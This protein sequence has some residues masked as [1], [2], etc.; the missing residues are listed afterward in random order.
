MIKKTNWNNWF[1]VKMK[2]AIFNFEEYEKFA[3][4]KIFKSIKYILKLILILAFIFTVS[5]IY[6]TYENANE[7]IL[8]VSKEIPEFKIEKDSLII[9][10]E[11]KQKPITIN[12]ENNQIGIIIDS[13]KTESKDIEIDIS[14]YESSV[15]FLKNK[16]VISYANNNLTATYKELLKE[17]EL[18]SISKQTVIDYI[19]NID[20]S[21]AYTILF[22]II[23]IAQF[24][25]YTIITI[26][27]IILL[28]I[29]GFLIT[30][31]FKV[32]FQYK[33]ILKISIYALTLPIILSAIYLSIN[34]ITGFTIKYFQTAYNIISYIYLITAILTIKTDLIKIKA[35][36][37]TIEKEAE[38][39]KKQKEAEEKLKENK[40]PKQRKK[41]KESEGKDINKKDNKLEK[42]K[43]GN[44]NTKTNKNLKPQDS[45]A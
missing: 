36:V 29:L 7:I 8:K 31:L 19:N 10:D 32:K 23:L 25:V 3:N 14:K 45:K 33:Q 18:N 9:E 11:S 6:I 5:Y 15:I 17:S 43:K 13:L 24:I 41:Q 44:T 26:I 37:L 20:F 1:F 40:V 42:N 21:K 39:M 4:E 35:E 28:S 34:T 16:M 22:T 27:N 38:E 2:K 12:S 30:K